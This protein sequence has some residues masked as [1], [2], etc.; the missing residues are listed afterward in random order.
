MS[1]RFTDMFTGVLLLAVG[2]SVSLILTIVAVQ[3]AYTGIGPILEAISDSGNVHAITLSLCTTTVASVLALLLA[4]PT[5]YALA[6]WNFKGV[7]LID[8][9]LV[10]PVVMSPMALGVALLLFFQ[11][12]TGKWID[13]DLIRFVFEVPGIILAQFFLAYAFSV[14]IIKATFAGIDVRLE[15]VARFLGCS[16]WKAFRHV[17]LPLARNGI[18]AAFILAWAR[19][20]GDFGSTSTI[21]GAVPGETETIPISIYLNL[22]TVSLDQSVALSLLLTFLT[23]AAVMVICFLLQKR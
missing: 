23:I 7:W 17:S 9:L 5:G 19:A 15:Q 13:R 4:I 2:I 22:A 20:I 18:L 11:T 3:A 16:R 12:S 14:L 8:A 6:R 10:V 21:G 1:Y